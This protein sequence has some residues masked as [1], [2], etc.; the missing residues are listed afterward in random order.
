[1]RVKQ[2]LNNWLIENNGL[3]FKYYWFAKIGKKI[4][5][6]VNHI[7]II[8]KKAYHIQGEIK[9]EEQDFCFK[10]IANIEKYEKYNPEK[11][12]DDENYSININ[13]L[14]ELKDNE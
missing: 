9:A 7:A 13:E 2:L 5:I 8:N 12:Y 14:H 6:T 3:V 10:E 1:M 11:T 4:S